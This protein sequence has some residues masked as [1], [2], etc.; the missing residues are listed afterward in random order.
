[1]AR[2]YLVRQ[3]ARRGEEDMAEG[4]ADNNPDQHIK[5]EEKQM[6]SPADQSSPAQGQAAGGQPSEGVGAGA[7]ASE[8]AAKTAPSK[9]SGLQHIVNNINPIIKRTK[10]DLDAC[11]SV[12]G[13]LIA[14]KEVRVQEHQND[15]AAAPQK[16]PQ[17]VESYRKATPC[18]SLWDQM[19]GTDQYRLC[20]GCHMFVYDFTGVDKEEA[21][22]SVFKREGKQNACFYRRED[23]RFLT[24]DCPIGVKRGRETALKLVAAVL[25][26]G[27]IIAVLCLVPHPQTSLTSGSQTPTADSEEPANL[28]EPAATTPARERKKTTK[29]AA[30]TQ[31]PELPG[32]GSDNVL[33]YPQ[34]TPSSGASP[35]NSTSPGTPPLPTP[36]A[37][38]DLNLEQIPDAVPTGS[39]PE[40]SAP[41]PAPQTASPGATGGSQTEGNPYVKN[42]R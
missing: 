32:P 26:V 39:Q 4:P 29:T 34:T 25:F 10:I 3:T 31:P 23:G 30:T 24:S 17:P 27:V 38:E 12:V 33:Q 8:Q 20:A 7:Q 11:R 13:K 37:R 1:M 36:P 40:V 6:E 42:Y 5:P 16:L 15:L 2:G 19:S 35:T 9:T 28:Q 22:L 18:G 14:D 41:A 21:D